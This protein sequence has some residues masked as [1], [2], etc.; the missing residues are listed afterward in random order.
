MDNLLHQALNCWLQQVAPALR[1]KVAVD[2]YTTEQV[3]L[4][5]A[6]EIAGLNYF[7]FMEKLREA[8]IA[9]V[10]AEVET[11]AQQEQ[12]QALLDEILNFPQS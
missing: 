2:L 6:A 9:L 4:G 3:S 11:E 7:V 12:Q 10:D 8:D 5:R 1:W